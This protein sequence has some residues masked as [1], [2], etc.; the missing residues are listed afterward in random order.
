MGHLSSYAGLLCCDR[1]EQYSTIRF[2]T[3]NLL[4]SPFLL[5]IASCAICFF[6]FALTKQIS[7]KTSNY[8]TITLLTKCPLT[9]SVGIIWLEMKVFSLCFLDESISSQALPLSQLIQN[10]DWVLDIPWSL[11]W[12]KVPYFHLKTMLN[13]GHSVI[14]TC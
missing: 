12:F 6:C 9:K 3:Q 13:L 1:I 7:I 8:I 4:S 14:W 11:S 5:A 10:C 2:C